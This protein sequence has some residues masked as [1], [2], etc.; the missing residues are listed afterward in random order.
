MIADVGYLDNDSYDVLQPTA[1][2]PFLDTNEVNGCMQVLYILRLHLMFNFQT[3]AVDAVFGKRH[4]Q[5]IEIVAFRY[6]SLVS[7]HLQ[8]QARLREFFAH[9]GQNTLFCPGK[10][11][12]PQKK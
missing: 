8:K 12:P 4:G 5:R 7:T 3:Y 2:I 9:F 10:P 11:P 6:L 1:W